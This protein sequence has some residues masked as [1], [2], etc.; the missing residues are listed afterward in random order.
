M[1]PSFKRTALACSFAL[2]V[3]AA[4]CYDVDDDKGGVNAAG[5]DSSTAGPSGDGDSTTGGDGFIAPGGV[6]GVVPG[7][8]EA[9][10]PAQ[11]TEMVPGGGHAKSKGHE[12]FFSFGEPTQLPGDMQSSQHQMKSGLTGATGSMK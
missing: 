3:G 1:R 6:G 10:K 5:G 2:C 8:Q 11:V 4:G 9:P 12:I 7:A